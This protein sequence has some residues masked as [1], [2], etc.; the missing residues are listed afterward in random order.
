MTLA[1][2]KMILYQSENPLYYFV[3][4]LLL[5]TIVKFEH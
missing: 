3:N 1:G 2:K 4:N 5:S